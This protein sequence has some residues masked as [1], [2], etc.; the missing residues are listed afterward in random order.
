MISK[1][2]TVNFL[3]CFFVS[4][5]DDPTVL[6]TVQLAET[7]HTLIEVK[8]IPAAQVN[9][10]QPFLRASLDFTTALLRQGEMQ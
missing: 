4:P 2:S 10:Y 7:L 1:V 6:A 3:C 5:N 9:L 8:P